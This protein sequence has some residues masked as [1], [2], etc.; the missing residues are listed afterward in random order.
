M[1]KI[2]HIGK[3]LVFANA[4]LIFIMTT[5]FSKGFGVTYILI[6]F[7]L[8]LIPSY[9]IKYSLIFRN[10]QLFYFIT[11]IIISFSYVFMGSGHFIEFRNIAW[12][13]FV[14]V[15]SCIY[16]FI[17]PKLN[18]RQIKFL[19]FEA[20]YC[21]LITLIATIVICSVDP[22]AVRRLGFGEAESNGEG[23]T[24]MMYNKF[25]MLSY[26][27]AHVL[28][29]IP[30]FC[31]VFL[32]ENKKT[33]SRVV[34]IVFLL[35]TFYTLFLA[36]ITTALLSSIFASLIVVLY[37]S[38][39]TNKLFSIITVLFVVYSMVDTSVVV[40]F[41]NI[42]KENAGYEL[43]N[44][45]SDLILSLTGSSGAQ[46]EGRGSLHQI[47][48]EGFLNN[49]MFGITKLE[50]LGKHSLVLDFLASYGIIGC[51]PLLLG[52]IS[53]IRSLINKLTKHF[54][55]LFIIS[56]LPII[57][58]SFAKG[59]VFFPELVFMTFVIMPL[60]FFYL[61]NLKYKKN[62]IQYFKA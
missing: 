40:W 62:G 13:Y 4:I 34:S 39:K 32:K 18:I 30:P 33:L 56:S 20:F 10:K 37:Y 24:Q 43:E 11:F 41:L 46:V 36:T 26:S 28:S 61:Q 2:N 52:V 45:L 51:L 50:K 8:L 49:P 17:L 55:K 6:L 23:F 21:I 44:K 27:F 3:D 29:V 15:L 53:G 54:R 14:V 31:I 57:I 38:Y 25:G 12:G 48:I 60:G 7:S 59:L 47:S 22:M 5:S 19:Y 16:S 1:T 35:L 42:L 58:L 9:I